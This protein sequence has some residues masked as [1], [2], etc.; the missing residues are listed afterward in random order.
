[1]IEIDLDAL[2]PS[3]WD[4][5]SKYHYIK[6]QPK[7]KANVQ[8]WKYNSLFPH[9]TL[10]FDNSPSFSKTCDTSFLLCDDGFQRRVS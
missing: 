5:D 1:M 3:T 7:D 2:F 4:E 10:V 9:E 8:I 6:I